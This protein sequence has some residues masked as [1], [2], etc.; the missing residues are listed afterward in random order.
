MFDFIMPVFKKRN[1]DKL[2]LEVL[3]INRPAI[4]VYKNLGF[5]LIR[6]LDCYN[7]TLNSKI[8]E[9]KFKVKTLT[10]YDWTL[11]QS[12]WD[13]S[14]TWQNSISTLIDLESTNT[15]KV[16]YVDDG[17]AGYVIL[18]S[19]EKRIHQIAIDKNYRNLG[20]GNQL[21][22]EV[23][24]ECNSKVSFINID[25]RI[26]HLNLFLV[27]RGLVKFTQQYEMEMVLNSY[28]NL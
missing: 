15:L 18:S 4:S 16:I 11:F 25:K 5:K 24:R 20:L 7:G 12:F 21:L 8:K 13:H 14:P 9:S 3:T 2:I 19:S 6:T 23:S 1:I 28:T 22:H 26:E 27:K 17:I 10:K